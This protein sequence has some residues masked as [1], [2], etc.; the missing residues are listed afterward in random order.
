MLQRR[1]EVLDFAGAVLSQ[2][3]S[4]ASGRVFVGDFRGHE[5]APGGAARPDTVPGY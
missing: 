1:L 2:D 3:G 4:D 5:D